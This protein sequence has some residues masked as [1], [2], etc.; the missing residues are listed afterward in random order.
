MGT[1]VDDPKPR[2]NAEA[3]NESRNR[4]QRHSTRGNEGT[5]QTEQRRQ[6]PKTKATADESR[7]TRQAEHRRHVT[8]RATKIQ[9]ESEGI[10]QPECR[11]IHHAQIRESKIHQTKRQMTSKF[12]EN[13]CNTNSMNNIGLDQETITQ[14]LNE[15][16]LH[17]SR[18][19]KAY[20]STCLQF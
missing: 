15:T 20:T 7:D 3:E 14:M 5:R 8:N 12:D 18:M 1:A 6:K 17:L 4:E 9:T 19:K 13:F 11:S 10:P 16:S 2:T